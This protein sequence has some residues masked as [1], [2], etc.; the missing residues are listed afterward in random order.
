MEEIKK[1]KF[2]TTK[3]VFEYCDTN[4]I[5]NG[6]YNILMDYDKENNEYYFRLIDKNTS[7]T[8]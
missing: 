6:K 2:K 3:E 8:S 4:N 1:I 5:E 7:K